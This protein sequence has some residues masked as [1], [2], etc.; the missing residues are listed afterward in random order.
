MAE[1]LS[2]RSR[3]VP[4]SKAVLDTLETLVCVDG[5]VDE[6]R[7]VACGVGGSFGC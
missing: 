2:D 7:R 6:V 3:D 5:S 4:I 1:S